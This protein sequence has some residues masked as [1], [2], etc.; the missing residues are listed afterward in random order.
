MKFVMKSK[1]LS[2]FS[3]LLM[4]TTGCQNS[5]TLRNLDEEQK[6]YIHE[7]TKNYG[8][9]IELY[10]NR[11]KQKDTED[12]R[13]KLAQTYYLLLDYGSAKHALSS[14]VDKS[15]NDK[16]LILYSRVL[17]R[18]GDYA[19]ALAYLEKAAAINPN[20][21]EGYN[22]QG[23]V[24]TR[25]GQYDAARASFNKARD[26]FYDENKVVNNLAMLSI[27]DKEYRE[28]YNYLNI[29]Y[30]KGY[31]NN[32][33]LHNILYTLVKL[34]E[35]QVAE[36]FCVEH[37]LSKRPT[38]LV[39]ELKRIEPNKIVNFHKITP[40]LSEKQQEYGQETSAAKGKNSSL[41]ASMPVN[42]APKGSPAKAA[43]ASN[44]TLAKSTTSRATKFSAVRSGEHPTFSR[45]TF[46]TVSKLDDAQYKVQ[47]RA[48][49]QV[50]ITILNI[51]LSKSMIDRIIK[52]VSRSHRNFTNVSGKYDA[53]S[54]T[55]TLLMTVK[56]IAN[57]K[58][59]YVG[60]AKN[61]GHLLAID[62]Y[63]AS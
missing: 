61:N 53:S 7:T 25:V 57:F 55:L 24:R 21:G 6:I 19:N 28:A 15:Q 56:D 31:R 8:G 59:F 26:L 23:I 36:R 46:E 10:K 11:L 34:N 40:S 29:L 2:I 27:L 14:V 38:I 32:V 9:L 35:D 18:Q 37:Q 49:N 50:E 58:S 44:T 4:V 45:I 62:F 60:K 22:L 16:T 1:Y 47:E 48:N 42:V 33:L 63:T 51:D 41:T 20:N 5:T 54:K 43:V 52:N 13:Y 30:K 12:S 39:Q 17:Y 3:V